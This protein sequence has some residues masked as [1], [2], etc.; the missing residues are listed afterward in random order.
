[1]ITRNHHPQMLW[2]ILLVGLIALAMLIGAVS[3]QAGDFGYTDF[4]GV[5]LDANNLPETQAGTH[6][7]TA[8][9]HIKFPLK[10]TGLE[11]DVVEHVRE[12]EVD[13]PPGFVGNT[14]AV[15]RCTI[16]QL[17]IGG[18]QCPASTQVGIVYTS[19]GFNNTVGL[20]NLV[21]ERGTVAQFGFVI[22]SNPA[23]ITARVRPDD[24]GVSAGSVDIEEWYDVP[25]LSVQLWGTPG[26]PR[27]DPYRDSMSNTNICLVVDATYPDFEGQCTGGA[28]L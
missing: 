26:D 12:L 23:T 2:T 1:M 8:T 27:H 19:T 25:D 21:P 5:V 15:P 17:S 20:Y 18:G 9:T 13:L 6:P 22:A 3:A 14:R 7:F 24:F 11:D 10:P 4:D 28:A 16:A